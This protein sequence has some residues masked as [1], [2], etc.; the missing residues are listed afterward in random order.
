[1]SYDDKYVLADNSFHHFLV[2]IFLG[3]EYFH[4]F[5]TNFL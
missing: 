5:L 3:G 4:L 2:V 1:M